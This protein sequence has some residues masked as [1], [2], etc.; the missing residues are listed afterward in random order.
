V[1]EIARLEQRLAHLRAE[2]PGAVAMAARATLL[3]PAAAPAKRSY[4]KNPAGAPRRAF[5]E[6]TK[7]KMAAAQRRRWA[8]RKK[9][10]AAG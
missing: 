2:F 8:A 9:A 4:T 6:A 10:Q 5:S 1:V 3:A 7:K